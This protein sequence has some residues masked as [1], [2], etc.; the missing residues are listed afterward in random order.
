MHKTARKEQ[1]ASI[2]TSALSS[3][4]HKTLKESKL[5]LVLSV[6]AVFAVGSFAGFFVGKNYENGFF[7]QNSTDSVL[8][9]FNNLATK[10]MNLLDMA[11]E[12]DISTSDLSSI[13]KIMDTIDS[14]YDILSQK[15]SNAYRTEIDILD[16]SWKDAV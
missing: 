2:K 8:N 13:R 10:A 11:S 5:L 14:K 9:Q 3:S 12:K 16:A 4:K 1:K 6:I 15:I 7:A